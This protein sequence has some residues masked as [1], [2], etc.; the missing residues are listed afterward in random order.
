MTEYCKVKKHMSRVCDFGTLGCTKDHDEDI[1]SDEEFDMLLDR[2]IVEAH[3][4]K[5]NA[6]VQ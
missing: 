1:I 3:R 2:A 4:R 6:S 5:K